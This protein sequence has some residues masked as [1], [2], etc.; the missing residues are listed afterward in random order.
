MERYQLVKEL[1]RLCPIRH[2]V[3]SRIQKRSPGFPLAKSLADAS[4]K[5]QNTQ[6]LNKE[7]DGPNDD[8]ENEWVLR[9]KGIFLNL[10]MAKG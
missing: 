4:T 5:F 8:V 1:F 3:S 2:N 10:H 6:E 9:L 7:A